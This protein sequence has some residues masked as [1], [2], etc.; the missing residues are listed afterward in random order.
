MELEKE[1]RDL[2][3]LMDRRGNPTAADVAMQVASRIR[4][5]LTPEQ[6]PENP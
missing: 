5:L 3:F 2:A 4:E 1:M 6:V